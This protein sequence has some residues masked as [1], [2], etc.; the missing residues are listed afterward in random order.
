MHLTSS[1]CFIAVHAVAESLHAVIMDMIIMAILGFGDFF[2][3]GG[4]FGAQV[5]IY[6]SFL[7]SRQGQKYTNGTKNMHTPT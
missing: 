2:G 6:L 1:P 4:E 3:G 7:K 5:F